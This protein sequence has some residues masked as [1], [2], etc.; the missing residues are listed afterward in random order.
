MN[1][2]VAAVVLAKDD[3]GGFNRSVFPVL[4]RPIVQYPMLS[5]LHSRRVDQ[6]FLSTSSSQVLQIAL[7]NPELHI[8]ER[9]KD[10]DS[11]F[12]EAICALRSIAEVHGETPEI[13]VVL[14]GNSPCVLPNMIDSAIEMIEQNPEVDSVLSVSKMRSHTPSCSMRLAPN[15]TMEFFENQELRDYQYFMDSRVM[16][17]RTRHLSD[18]SPKGEHFRNFFGKKVLP[19]F[20]DDSVSDID[21]IWQVPQVERW[22]QTQGFSDQALPESIKR[23]LGASVSSGPERVGGKDKLKVFVSTVPFGEI[24]PTP[25]EQMK[26]E[27]RCEYLINPIGRKLREEELADFLETEKVDVL[28]AGTEPVSAAVMDRAKSLKLISR[29]GIGLDSVDLHAA[30]KRDIKVSYTP[31]APAPAVAELTIGHMINLN[32]YIPLVDRKL[33]EGIWQRLMGYRLGNQVIGLFGAG[34]VGSRVLKHLQGFAPKRILVNDVLDKSDL[35]QLYG[36]EQASKE[37]I[38]AQCD[39]VSLHLPLTPLTKNF[40]S[41][42]ELELMKKEASL[43]NTSR[44]GIVHEDDLYE[45]L[46]AGLIRGAAID[47]FEEEPYAGNL[48]TLDSCFVSCH[49][50]SCSKDC[51]FEMEKFATE[52]AMRFIRGEALELE[53]PEFEFDIQKG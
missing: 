34:R 29:V 9:S 28:I 45:V 23:S 20:H 31:D 48:L 46:K 26:G 5:G 17:V 7:A 25:I 51:R 18:Y 19:V 1:L 32:R 24:D 6:T 36:A 21:Y 47:V 30:R 8:L 10:Q 13:L 16:V 35:F 27:A 37:E 42:P 12:Q 22:L 40:I 3:E 50:G 4:G 33:R 38:L 53:V 39:I 52:E 49:M 41:K 43:V 11:F 15:H 14:L 2:K 44:G